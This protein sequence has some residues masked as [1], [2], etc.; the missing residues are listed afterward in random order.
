MSVI[1]SFSVGNGDMFYIDHNSDNFTTIDCC[2]YDDDNKHEIFDE[3]KK[4]SSKKGI[5]RFISTH[6]DDDHIKGLK[7]F[8][9]K[10][11]IWNFYCVEN[12]TTKSDETDDFNKYCE[13]RDGKKCFYLIK[14]CTRK[15]LNESDKEY[16]SDG[17]KR[18]GSGIKC[19][20]PITTN[21]DYKKA[22]EEAK[23]GNSP[24]NISPIIIY[25]SNGT[26]FMWMGDMMSDFIEKVKDT[27]S[28]QEIDILFAPHH[29]R[30]RVP[31]GVL[32]KLK[33]K[34]LVIGEA[35]SGDLE[36]YPKTEYNTITQ[37]S[38]G[39]IIFEC[40]TNKVHIFVSNENYSVDFLDNENQYDRND[41]YYL[42]TLNL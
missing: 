34:I 40:I 32:N 22:L 19:L 10:I 11:G 39:D 23:E 2:Y 25:S 26:K 14:G 41:G 17:I 1:K 18:E 6:P 13:L 4:K 20:W 9:N 24:N 3:I 33:P 21:E 31:K 42:G 38:A 8:C 35:K 12:K 30:E 5:T 37:N 15:W 36:Y 7:D 27:I 16:N 29:G 28:W